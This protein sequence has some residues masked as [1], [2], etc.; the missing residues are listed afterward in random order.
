[1][2]T[3][4]NLKD[5]SFLKIKLR[6]EFIVAIFYTILSLFTCFPGTSVSLLLAQ[7]ILFTDDFSD[8]DFNGWVVGMGSW[9]AS[10]YAL[11][12]TSFYD[13]HAWIGYSCGNTKWKNYVLEFDWS[14]GNGTTSDGHIWFRVQDE[15]PPIEGGPQPDNGYCL[16]IMDRSKPFYHGY[17]LYKR[18][19]GQEVSLIE[20]TDIPDGLSLKEVL[21]KV[22]EINESTKIL[23]DLNG[24]PLTE[25]ID[26]DPIRPQYGGICIDAYYQVTE[27]TWDNFEITD[28]LV[29]VELTAF[30]ATVSDG[31]VILNWTTQTETENYGFHVYRS[32]VEDKDYLKITRSIIP[33]AGTSAVVHHY[34]YV[35]STVVP[36]ST[37]YYKLASIDYNGNVDYHGPISAVVTGV[38]LI[39]NSKLPDGFVLEQNYPNPFNPETTIRFT[40]KKSGFV[41]LSIYDLQGKLVRTLVEGERSV[42]SYSVTWNGTDDQ[43]AKVSSGSYF[44]RLHVD[45]FEQIR[46]L[47]FL[48]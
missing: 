10:T 13:Q 24:S 14:Y 25:Y 29:P 23:V 44:Y 30:T 28:Y 47:I 16:Q 1:M 45:R 43:G 41:T 33:G 2:I 18:V 35:D 3:N 27:Q 11:K 46:K 20:Q 36:S 40:L 4:I 37:Y 48:K 34:S 5:F 9:D 12:A 8:G 22:F 7:E 17:T 6:K 39:T 19:N 15:N 26:T 38:H 21:I 42:G 31:A 32:L